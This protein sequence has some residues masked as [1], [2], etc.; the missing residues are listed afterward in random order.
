[1][2]IEKKVFGY[3]EKKHVF[4]GGVH[5][6]RHRGKGIWKGK[7]KDGR[8][9]QKRDSAGKLSRKNCAVRKVK[10]VLGHQQ[11]LRKAEVNHVS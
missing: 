2:R 1:M 3:G 6:P 7:E 11:G 5:T 4:N 10:K 9:R 8:Y